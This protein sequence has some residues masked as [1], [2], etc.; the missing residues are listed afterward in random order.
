MNLFEI[1]V[2]GIYL[3]FVIDLL[4]FP[5]P[6]EA[7]TYQLFFP[8]SDTE[9]QVSKNLLSRIQQLPL[10]LKFVLL[11]LPT[12]IGLLSYLL[13]LLVI[14]IPALQSVFGPF[15]PEDQMVL[16][17]VGVGI[18]IF[19]RYLSIYSAIQ[20]RK[21]QVDKKNLKEYLFTTNITEML[22]VKSKL[23]QDHRIE[24]YYDD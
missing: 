7:S 23:N 12:A 14:L 24:V 17:L 15:Q 13:P 21:Q 19:G 2:I 10:V 6:S 4:G 8:K 22:A 9:N 5:V 11:L 16:S 18:A 1:L 3:S 20:I